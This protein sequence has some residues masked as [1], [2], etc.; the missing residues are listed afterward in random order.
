MRS[1][2]TSSP[3]VGTLSDDQ[4]IEGVLHMVGT[5]TPV[6]TV[7]RRARFLPERLKTRLRRA[8]AGTPYEEAIG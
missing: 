3:A 6:A 5:G 8:L 7:K 2:V 4:V 1:I